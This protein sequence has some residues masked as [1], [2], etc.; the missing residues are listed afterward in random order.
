MSKPA[1]MRRAL[2]RRLAQASSAALL[3]GSAGML[4]MPHAHAAIGTTAAPDLLQQAWFWQNA[5]EQANPPVAQQPPANEPTGVPDGDLAVAFTG[6]ASGGSSKMT[7]LSWNISALTPGTV[8]NDFTFT[9]TLDA[10]NPSATNFDTTNASV[11]ACQPTRLWPAEMQGDYTD[12]PT[13]D[14]ANKVKPTVTGNNYTFK[15]PTIAQSWIDDQNIGVAIVNDPGNSSVPFQLVFTGGKTIKATMDYTPETAPAPGIGGSTSGTTTG[16]I[17]TGGSTPAG[18]GGST[19]APPPVAVPT[20]PTTGTAQP[21]ATTPQVAPASNLGGAA[22]AAAIK[23]ASA[24][25]TAA[26]WLAGIGLALLLLVT[27]LVLGDPSSAPTTA[28][29]SRLDRVLRDRS[30]D[31]FTVRSA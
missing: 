2:T 3:A 19:S 30:T 1:I 16:P 31:A 12:Q 20:G 10:S 14:C 22:P 27:S 24:A 13:V 23:P 28:E 25:P 21:P 8:I 17:S 9:L 15:I 5:Y 18:T 11:V 29:R 7:A 4:L 6:S 26:F